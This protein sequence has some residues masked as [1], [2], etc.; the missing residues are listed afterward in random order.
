M[1]KIP[2]LFFLYHDPNAFSKPHIAVKR[3]KE[4]KQGRKSL[5]A[6]P[7][8]PGRL[9]VAVV[10]PFDAG[11]VLEDI[12]ELG[13]GGVLD[14][15]LVEGG[16][17]VGV[18]GEEVAG[19]EVVGLKLDDGTIAGVEL[20]LLSTWEA[21]EDPPPGTA[22]IPVQKDRNCSNIGFTYVLNVSI[23]VSP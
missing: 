7:V 4:S 11:A 16:L 21:T 3:Y 13:F 2:P 5:E 9:P 6:A 14:E 17:G 15:V 8:N 18:T 23:F 12:F 20:V 22:L 10:V 19:G 1:Q